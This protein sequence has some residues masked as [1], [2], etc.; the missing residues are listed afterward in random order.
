[1]TSERV[2]QLLSKST[3]PSDGEDELS[4]LSL[5]NPEDEASSTASKDLIDEQN[6][7]SQLWKSKKVLRSHLDSVRS[8]TFNPAYNLNN[9]S[10]LSIVSA[11][12]DNTIKIWKLD[13]S[14]F[15][16]NSMKLNSLGSNSTTGG[17][18]NTNDVHPFMTFRGHSASITS[19]AISNNCQKLFSAS[20]DSSIK[21]WRLPKLNNTSSI[22]SSLNA[23]TGTNGESY[24]PFD[25]TLEL[26]SLIGHT[27]SIW[28]ISILPSGSNNTSE[29]DG[30]STSN[31]LLA[32]V[33]ADGTT[34][35][36]NVHDKGYELKLS[37]D[38]FGNDLN[39]DSIKEKEKFEEENKDKDEEGR[40]S[41]PI[42]TS[43]NA[44]HWNL[45]TVAVAYSNSIVK[46]FEI[47]TGKE[48][49]KLS[50][51]ETYGEF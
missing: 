35:I 31:E 46:L 38:Y 18:G 3:N 17:G 34:K 22:N 1:M 21:V 51:D 41:L 10:T 20:L 14:S 36:W 12:D 32:S 13:P 23:G 43:V 16:S 24:Q 2:N 48:V 11:S 40:I 45:K 42:P 5:P 7:D 15:N 9:S 30:S 26:N 44:C 27:Q 19:L 29:E 25:D 28:D 49:L 6:L 37:W 50:S 4:N 33:S 8:V 47:E 39:E